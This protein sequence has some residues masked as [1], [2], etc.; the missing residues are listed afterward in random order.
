MLQYAE[1][2]IKPDPMTIY[3]NDREGNY[4]YEQIENAVW[5]LASRRGLKKPE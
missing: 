5:A 1:T 4:A 2:V 3:R